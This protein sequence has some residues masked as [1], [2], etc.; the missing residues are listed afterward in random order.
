MLK[1]L[2]FLVI[3]A[4]SLSEVQAAT[5]KI[6]DEDQLKT[7]VDSFSVAIV[8]KDKAW[9]VSNLSESCKM[10][11]PTGNTLDRSGIVYTF[12]QGIYDISKSTTL[13]KTFKIDGLLAS[14]TS[15]FDVEGEGSVNGNKMDITGR[16]RFNLKFTKIDSGWKISE[17]TINQS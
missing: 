17:I 4:F 9:I 11:E 6:G 12:T 14:C 7:L 5:P 15:D 10:F 2:L 8:K 13:N 1:K 3:I 16:Y